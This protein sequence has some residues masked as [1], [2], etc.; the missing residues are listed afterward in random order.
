MSLINF[1]NFVDEAIKIEQNIDNLQPLAGKRVFVFPFKVVSGITN[2]TENGEK[3]W[4]YDPKDFTSFFSVLNGKETVIAVWENSTTSYADE[5]TKKSPLNGFVGEFKVGESIN[6]YVQNDNAAVDF[7]DMNGLDGF[8]AIKTRKNFKLSFG[9]DSFHGDLSKKEEYYSYIWNVKDEDLFK[10]Y[11]IP[12]LFGNAWLKIDNVNKIYS[13]IGNLE[14]VEVDFSTVGDAL[15]KT[16]GV[17]VSLIQPSCSGE[18]YAWPKVIETIEGFDPENPKIKDKKIILDESRLMTKPVTSIQLKCDGVAALNTFVAFGRPVRKSELTPTVDEDGIYRKRITP[19]QLLLPLR[20]LGSYNDHLSWKSLPVDNFYVAPHSKATF[21][22]FYD[23]WKEKMKSNYDPTATANFEGVLQ[24][25]INKEEREE[26]DGSNPFQSKEFQKYKYAL[27]DDLAV[28]FCNKTVFYG[29]QATP[30]CESNLSFEAWRQMTYAQILCHN[31][32]ISSPMT[33]L[34]QGI[35][36]TTTWSLQDIPIVGGF[37]NTMLSGA[38]FGFQVNSTKIPTPDLPFIIPAEIFR[39]QE[40][41]S[42][43]KDFSYNLPFDLFRFGKSD[44]LGAAIGFGNLN[45]T[46]RVS[47]TNSYRNNADNKIYNTLFLGQRKNPDGTERKEELWS[48]KC[49]P[50]DPKIDEED[51]VV[52]YT[53]DSIYHKTLYSGNYVLTLLSG[54]TTEFPIPINDFKLITKSSMTNSIREWTN[55]YNL[56]FWKEGFNTQDTCTWPESLVLPI[57][58]QDIFSNVVANKNTL[59]SRFDYPIILV[60]IDNNSRWV[61]SSTAYNDFFKRGYE[62]DGQGNAKMTS[63]IGNTFV[64]HD[65]K[66]KVVMKNINTKWFLSTDYTNISRHSYRFYDIPDNIVSAD[67]VK[68]LNNNIP[69]TAHVKDLDEIL[70][71]FSAITFQVKIEGSNMHAFNDPTNFEYCNDTVDVHLSRQNIEDMKNGKEINF[72][73]EKRINWSNND[74]CRV[75]LV[76]AVIVPQHWDSGHTFY[77]ELSSAKI[78]G[79]KIAF[80]FKRICHIMTLSP[81]GPGGTEHF[82]THNQTMCLAINK[83]TYLK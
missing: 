73:Y 26:I 66:K 74:Q 13:S 21:R 47:L 27:K 22:T 80:S 12:E 51:P 18:G 60:K 4:K 75:W 35:N 34:P 76:V 9:V 15:A 33:T 1:Q 32:F 48:S 67:L 62:F 42:G 6:G 41:T 16:A 68:S 10:F 2:Y 46:L 69:V 8:M 3:N 38:N 50:I 57:R 82:Y 55:I 20:T 53:T 11:I 45:T 28:Q 23:N 61:D 70:T 24:C 36:S 77:G 72:G 65:W 56:S 30:G 7:S 40:A 44:Q 37:L 5:L 25:A 31:Y 81:G 59:E 58:N 64:D 52:G 83:I 19:P 29:T 79:N 17:N 14:R 49:I 71:Q 63:A 78:I 39:F 43:E 54:T